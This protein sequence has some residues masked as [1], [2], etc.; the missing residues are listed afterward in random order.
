[1]VTVD[2]ESPGCRLGEITWT[3]FTSADVTFLKASLL[4]ITTSCSVRLGTD[5][6]KKACVRHKFWLL[7]E[8]IISYWSRRWLSHKTQN[9]ERKLLFY[10]WHLLEVSRLLQHLEFPLRVE[11]AALPLK[12]C[13]SQNVI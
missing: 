2:P 8:S 7:Q 4:I 6:E 11:S 1:M 3:S 10:P 13:Q 9:I 5:P 12:H